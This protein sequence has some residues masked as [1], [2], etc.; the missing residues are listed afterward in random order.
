M[1]SKLGSIVASTDPTYHFDADPDPDFYLMR[2]RIQIFNRCGF[3]SDFS[4][5]GDRILLFIADP[6]PEIHAS[7]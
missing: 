3:G 5:D 1:E 7:D 2:I 4:H 6:D